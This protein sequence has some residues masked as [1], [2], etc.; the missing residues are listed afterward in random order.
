[1]K[2]SETISNCI[3]EDYIKYLYDDPCEVLV[4]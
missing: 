4:N 1:L 2:N 3:N